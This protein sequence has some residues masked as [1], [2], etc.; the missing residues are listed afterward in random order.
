MSKP[1]KGKP[2]TYEQAVAELP[3][4][5]AALSAESAE[6]SY[7]YEQS[8]RELHRLYGV[9][10]REK[11]RTA[12]ARLR[13]D[14]LRDIVDK[15]NGAGKRALTF[16]LVPNPM[17]T[18]GLLNAA[19]EGEIETQHEA[20]QAAA[21]N[22]VLLVGGLARVKSKTEAQFLAAAKYCNLY[23]QSQIG[24]ARATDYTKIRVNTAG[25]GPDQTNAR[26]QEASA[27]LDGARKA[28]GRRAASIV[29]HVVVYGASIRDLAQKIGHGSGGQ[30]RR[31]AEAELLA[32]LDVLVD[33]FGLVPGIAPQSS[34]RQRELC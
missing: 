14:T 2:L 25:P 13:V 6:Y 34:I 18:Q 32:A 12:T 19:A 29:D 16:R 11:V 26:R 30:G 28:L 27:E 10:A 4:A 21:F 7:A 1:R 24:G 20:S 8:V 22:E 23:E 3:A 15:G 17:I 5:E 33:L 31:R 9:M